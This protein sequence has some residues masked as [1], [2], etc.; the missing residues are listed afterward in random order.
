M[1]LDRVAA[2]L[3]GEPAYRVRQ[4]WE[5]AARGASSYEEMT[6]LPTAARERLAEQAPF[7]TL[8]SRRGPFGRRDA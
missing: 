2:A 3:A 1:N 7:S 8:R 5:W 6:N 4:V